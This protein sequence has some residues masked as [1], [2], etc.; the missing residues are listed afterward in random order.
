MRDEQIKEQYAAPT[1]EK[2]QQ[3]KDVTEGAANGATTGATSQPA[4]GPG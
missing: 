3:L 1:L 2:C 4:P